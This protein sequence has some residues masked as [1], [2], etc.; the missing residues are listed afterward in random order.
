MFRKCRNR[1][2]FLCCCAEAWGN[3][4][5]SLMQEF[6]S[7]ALLKKR[8]FG[9]HFGEEVDIMMSIKFELVC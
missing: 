9:N 7:C 3:N 6:Q 5:R 4:P 2:Q 1:C 8:Q